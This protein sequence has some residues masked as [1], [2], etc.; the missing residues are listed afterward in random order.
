MLWL[1]PPLVTAALMLALVWQSDRDREPLKWVLGTFVLGALLCT[2]TLWLEGRVAIW[3]GAWEESDE[4]AY[5][6][7][8]LALVFGLA[9][10]LREA[11]KLFATLPAFRS[12]HFD[13]PYDAIVYSAAASLG[14]SAIESGALLRSHPPTPMWVL[15]ALLEVPASVFFAGIW[16]YGLGRARVLGRRMFSLWFLASLMHG[17]YLYV[18]F[19]RGEATALGVLPLLTAMCLVAIAVA[20]DL[21][22]REVFAHEGLS[23]QGPAQRSSF[24]RLPKVPAFSVVREALRP[25]RDTVRPLWVGLGALVTIGAM[26]LAFVVAIVIAKYTHFDFA[27]V[28]ERNASTLGP[29]VLLTGCLLGAFPVAGFALA[30]ATSR[31]EILEPALAS[32]LAILLVIICMGLAAPVSLVFG[33]ILSPLAWFLACSGAWFGKS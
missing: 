10:P 27:Q 15:R 2:P 31:T 3:T 21:R 14:F 12:R 1:V 18:L 16:A 30:R 20:R 32:A 13:Q 5:N 4:V 25:K 26:I 23:E 6:A 29:L 8:S 9:A 24:G 28:D 19:G 33:V 7:S 22:R 11:V 17:L